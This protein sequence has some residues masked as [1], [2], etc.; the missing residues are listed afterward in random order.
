MIHVL[1][2]YPNLYIII[3][4]K[5]LIN[6]NLFIFKMKI[7]LIKKYINN[8]LMILKNILLYLNKV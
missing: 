1:L 3:K 8:L 4:L 5:I 6:L 2:H 7:K